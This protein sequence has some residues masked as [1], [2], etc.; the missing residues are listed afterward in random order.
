MRRLGRW[1][2]NFLTVLS[3]LL[4]A[5]SIVLWVRSYWR[6]D[7]LMVFRVNRQ[8][9]QRW[10][11]RQPITLRS[12]RVYEADSHRGSLRL[13]FLDNDWSYYRGNYPALWSSAEEG[14]FE[15]WSPAATHWPGFAVESRPVSFDIN[16]DIARPGGPPP[17][18]SYTV[19]ALYTPWALWTMLTALL[20]AAAVWRWRHGLSRSRRGLC[21]ACG[22]SLTGNL[23]GVCPECGRPLST[24][25]VLSE[26]SE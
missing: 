11:D 10:I 4:C 26:S 15:P 5:A 12:G 13:L 2:R 22:Y 8:W 16:A 17:S 7:S 14:A 19:H 25:G 20:P 24:S 9:T 21:I 6:I 3:L 18:V 1:L 23:S